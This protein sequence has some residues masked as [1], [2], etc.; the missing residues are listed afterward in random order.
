[1]ADSADTS[2]NFEKSGGDPTGVEEYK[3]F[4]VI[5]IVGDDAGPINQYRPSQ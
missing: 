5:D 2:C 1:M 3:P 4:P